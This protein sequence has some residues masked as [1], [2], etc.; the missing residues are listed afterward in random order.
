MPFVLLSCQVVHIALLLGMAG[1]VQLAPKRV[2]SFPKCKGHENYKT[3]IVE[4]SKS[5]WVLGMTLRKNLCFKRDHCFKTKN[6]TD[7]KKLFLF[8]LM[9]QKHFYLLFLTLICGSCSI[10]FW[11]KKAWK[12][13]AWILFNLSCGFVNLTGIHPWNF[14]HSQK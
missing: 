8:L 4:A 10:G 9:I 14:P 2:K 1:I 3:S 11:H 7:Y 5:T 12:N 6:S 13:K